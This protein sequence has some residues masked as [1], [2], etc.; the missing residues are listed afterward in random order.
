MELSL[1]DANN[2]EVRTVGLNDAIFGVE[3]RADLIAMTVNYQLAKRRSGTA[4]TKTRREVAGGG[5][6]PYR[7]K[8][9]GR[10]RQGTMRAPQFRGGGVVFGPHPRDYSFKLNKKVRRLALLSALSAKRED[11]DIILVEDFGLTEIKTKT[12]RSVLANLGVERS[13]LI[14]LAE[15]D[16][17]VILSARNLPAITVMRSEGVNVH[18]L[19]SHDKLVMTESALRKLEERLA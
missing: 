4:D 3:P 7:Q 8:G 6:K 16:A 17:I 12:M 11:G 2:R 15:D 18:D 19:L 5:R 9:T 10:A 1:R 13:A 14:V